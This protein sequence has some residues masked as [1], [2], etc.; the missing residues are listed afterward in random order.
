MEAD[1]SRIEARGLRAY[2]R[3]RRLRAALLAAPF[4]IV[5]VAAACLG[6]PAAASTVAIGAIVTIAWLSFWRGRD[7]ARG[8]LPGILAGLVPFAM[9]HLAR[10]FDHVCM[11]SAC[12]LICIPVAFAGGAVAGVSLALVARRRRASLWFA[13]V[14]VAV[15]AA[16]GSLACTVIGF[17]EVLGLAVGLAIGM[18]PAWR[19]RREV[20]S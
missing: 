11:G 4:G 15:A 14:G 8:V 2:E 20:G 7:A 9:I 6:T 12:W 1:T 3:G 18:V 16:L 13:V 19:A 5:G 17:G 10:N